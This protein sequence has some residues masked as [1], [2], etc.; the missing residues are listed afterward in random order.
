MLFMIILFESQCTKYNQPYSI[1]IPPPIIAELYCILVEFKTP[2]EPT[3]V[4]PPPVDIAVFLEMKE[5]T[6]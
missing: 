4:I 2:R 1:L 6:I 3:N 5:D